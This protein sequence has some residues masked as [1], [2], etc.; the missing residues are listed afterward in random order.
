M[1]R[2]KHID[3]PVL[4]RAYLPESL[5]SR[6]NLDLYSEFEGRVPYGAMTKWLE[7]VT[8]KYLDE[9]GQSNAL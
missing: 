7:G 5:Y 6:L 1:P 3:R 2:V 9:K 8:Q 4:I